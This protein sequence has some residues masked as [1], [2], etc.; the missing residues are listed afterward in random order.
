MDASHESGGVT[1]KLRIK[2]EVDPCPDASGQ[3]KGRARVGVSTTRTGG[4]VG[5][6]GTL[7]V[8]VTGQVN[9]DAKLGTSDADY[10]MEWAEFGGGRGSYVDVS[11]AIGDTKIKGATIDRTGGVP[12]AALQTSAATTGL[13]YAAMIRMKIADAAQKGWE[14]GRCV[15]L[16]PT[17]APGPKGLEPSATSKIS[18]APRSRIDGAAVGGSVIATLSAGGA[19]VAPSATKVP[20]DATFTYTAPGEK[21]KTGT[22]SLD[23]RSRRGVAKASIDFDT[24]APG[25]YHVTGGLQDFQ[26]NQ[27]VC[28]ITKPFSLNGGIGVANFSGGL[29]GSYTAKGVFDFSYAGTYTISLP[30]GPGQPGSMAA[31]SSGSIAGQAGSGTERYALTPLESC[32]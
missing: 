23:A 15:A 3:F 17:A 2:V 13:L 11:G 8:A 4:S 25:A 6:N 19:S 12:N 1:T 29:S 28:D 21:N 9:D 31:T 16:K 7:D 24:S 30:N 5:Q 20:A 18:A 10:R 14:S 26:V 22:V 27:D 32:K